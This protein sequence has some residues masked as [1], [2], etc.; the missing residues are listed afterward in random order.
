MAEEPKGRPVRVAEEE[1]GTFEPPPVLPKTA[2]ALADKEKDLVALRDAAVEAAGVSGPLWISYL[3]VLLYLAISAGAVTHKD[4]FLE[5]PVKLPFLG[6]DLPLTGFFALGPVLFLILHIYVLLHFVLL[7]GKV[8][9]FDRE[10]SAQLAGDD[11]AE[12]RTNL[13]RQLP[14]NIFIQFLAGPRDVRERWVGWALRAIAWISLVFGPVLLLVFFQFRFLPYHD[15]PLTWWHRIAVVIDISL[16]WWLW[17][18]IVRATG[19]GDGTRWARVGA[20]AMRTASVALVLLVWRVATFPGEKLHEVPGPA[21]WIPRGFVAFFGVELKHRELGSL[22]DILFDGEV[23]Q[24]NR[25]PTS[26]FSNVLVLPGV[27][28]YDPAKFDDDKKFATVRETVSLR[29]RHLEGAVLIDAQ[30]RKVDLTGARLERAVLRVADLR[31]ANLTGARLQGGRLD[32]ARLQGA[33]L[34]DVQLQGSSLNFARL[35]GARLYGSANLQGAT[36]SHARLQG[37]WLEMVELQGANLAHAQLQGAYLLGLRLHGADLSGAMLQGVMLRKSQL[38]GVSLLTDHVAGAV[39]RGNCVWRADSP[40]SAASVRIRV[41]ASA[42]RPLATETAEQESSICEWSSALREQLL[43]D[44]ARVVPEGPRRDITL[45]R[46]TKALLPDP[47]K[48][49]NFEIEKAKS[50]HD[51]EAALRDE[52]TFT[53]ARQRAWQDAGCELDGAP[54]V[55][56]GLLRQIDPDQPADWERNLAGELLDP[57]CVGAAKLSADEKAQLAQIRDS[58]PGR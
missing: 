34:K 7:A 10:L 30:L 32:G 25:R 37:A 13:R 41:Y 50:W 46:L 39:L 9:A 54:Y 57:A 16:L 14:S 53:A 47:P 49:A 18:R 48:L 44:V 35:Q 1:F 40:N 36:L 38:N 19:D 33:F 27:E 20:W 2:Q 51:L 6:V 17:P 23:D 3:F 15:A 52:I 11:E 42:M 8:A 22:H 24:V 29:G 56:R 12:R 55:A 31:E 58:V 26:L 5:R 4:L 45:L 43:A 28:A 21:G